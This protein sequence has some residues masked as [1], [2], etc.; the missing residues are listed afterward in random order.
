MQRHFI[1]LTGRT[2]QHHR[3]L[4]VGPRLLGVVAQEVHRLADVGNGIVQRLARLAHEERREARIMRLVKIGSLVQHRGARIATQQVP[5]HLGGGSGIHGACHSRFIG[6]PHRANHDAAI[7]GRCDA[8]HRTARFRLS[9][10][11][12]MCLEWLRQR[13]PHARHELVARAVVPQGQ[14]LRVIA[15]GEDV[16]RKRDLRMR[17][18][19]KLRDL[20]HRIGDDFGNR[21]LVI[22]KPVDEGGVGTIFEQAAHQIGQQILMAAHGRINAAGLVHLVLPHHLFVE[23]LTHAVETL[24]LEAAVIA[25]HHRNGRQRMR[26]VGG[27]LRI[28]HIPP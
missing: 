3:A 26:I 10:H 11:Q 5:L 20:N 19:S 21:G 16:A 6:F 28:E 14:P 7:R 18:L 25:R 4:E 2:R 9:I 27:E 15:A 12:R 23:R 8:A 17:N 24:E 22:G 1:P 13:V